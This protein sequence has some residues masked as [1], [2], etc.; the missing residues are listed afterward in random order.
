MVIIFMSLILYGIDS[1]DSETAY[2]LIDNSTVWQRTWQGHSTVEEL[3]RVHKS[4]ETRHA[5]LRQMT[6]C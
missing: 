6:E 1:W 3:L 4:V 2:A 5:F